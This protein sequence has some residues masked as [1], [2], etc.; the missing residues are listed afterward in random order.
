[1]TPRPS[2]STTL[3]AEE[4]RRFE[5]LASDIDAAD[6]GAAGI[7]RDETEEA[8]DR[9]RFPCAIRAEERKQFAGGDGQRK[10]IDGGS[11]RAGE[12]FGEIF[13]GEHVRW[14]ENGGG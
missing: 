7:G 4:V 11:G 1:M 14:G 5:R 2:S 10:V 6:D 3:D 12:T 9:C 13:G 8:I